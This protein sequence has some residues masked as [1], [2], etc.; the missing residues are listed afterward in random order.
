MSDET[1]YQPGFRATRSVSSVKP[2][3][4]V[5][6]LILTLPSAASLGDERFFLRWCAQLGSRGSLPDPPVRQDLS[7]SVRGP[8]PV[9]APAGQSQKRKDIQKIS[10]AAQVEG[11]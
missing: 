9:P 7:A 11:N 1:F 5:T 10:P 3:A 4:D 6:L 8:S 2:N